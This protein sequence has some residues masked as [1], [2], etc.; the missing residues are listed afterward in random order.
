MSALKK[1]RH[2]LVMADSGGSPCARKA[3]TGKNG[4]IG[5]GLLCG[6]KASACYRPSSGQT[7][8]P[9]A[10]TPHVGREMKLHVLSDFHWKI[11]ILSVL[12]AAGSS[13]GLRTTR[14]VVPA[15]DASTPAQVGAGKR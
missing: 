7:R 12:K 4:R 13:T 2:R 10:D 6:I 15:M 9:V 11:G 5:V 3:D 8:F 1:N 14:A